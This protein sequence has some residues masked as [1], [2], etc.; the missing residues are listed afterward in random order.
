MDYVIKNHNNV[1]IR[2]NENGS[3]VSC[4]EKDRGFFEHSKA[5]NILN[6]LPKT[7]KKMG[8]SVEPVP[9]IKQKEE[10]A[11][12]VL[13]NINY[14]VPETVTRWVEKFGRCSDVIDEAKERKEEII[15]SLKTLDIEL[16]DI[17]HIIEIEAPKNMF[18]AWKIYKAIREIRIKRRKLKDELLIVKNIT[19]NLNSS[20]LQRDKIQRAINGL[21]NRK[22]TF[23]IIEEGDEDELL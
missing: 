12:R 20:Y 22:Y 15:D 16:V 17:L 14:E 18:A 6:S 10:S 5:K 9:E 21:A 4:G 11:T 2:L 1:Y 23:R 7:L 19:R 8:F 13:E 3:A